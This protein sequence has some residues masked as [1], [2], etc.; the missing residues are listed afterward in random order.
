MMN[1][2]VESL[3]D[4]WF[5]TSLVK[6]NVENNIVACKKILADETVN[7]DDQYK[8]RITLNVLEALNV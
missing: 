3:R 1:L 6:C 2:L 8:A 7:V 4:S 5:N